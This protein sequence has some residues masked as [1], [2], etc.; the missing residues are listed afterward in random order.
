MTLRIS[1]WFYKTLCVLGAQLFPLIIVL[2]IRYL[3]I[4]L[5]GKNLKTYF[6]GNL[7]TVL[8][9]LHFFFLA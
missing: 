3:M 8:K 7:A 9:F 4:Y 6:C 2:T 1:M 5:V